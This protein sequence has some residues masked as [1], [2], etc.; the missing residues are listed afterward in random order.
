[1]SD[2]LLAIL[3]HDFRCLEEVSRLPEVL[4]P[5]AGE[6]NALERMY[7]GATHVDAEGWRAARGSEQDWAENRCVWMDG[8]MSIGV[9]ARC[10]MLQP[11]AKWNWVRGQPA[12]LAAAGS[13]FER[14]ARA[15]G[16]AWYLGT[17]GGDTWNDV[18]EGLSV[19][20][21]EEKLDERGYLRVATLGD[22]YSPAPV[23]V[24]EYEYD[25]YCRCGV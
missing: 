2:H 1:M 15:L 13:F 14:A 10:V 22:F 6:A 25:V 24:P 16:A 19:L 9:G 8:P 3:A 7:F 12:V 17:H 20:E 11:S 5:L 21:I 18:T 23:A 4:R